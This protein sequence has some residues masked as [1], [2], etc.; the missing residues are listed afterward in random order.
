MIVV[1]VLAANCVQVRSS[2]HA[3]ESLATGTLIVHGN[4]FLIKRDYEKALQ[5]YNA[6]MAQEPTSWQPYFGRA[7][8]FISQRKW[9][10]A[11][12]DL[13]SVVRLKPGQLYAALLRGDVNGYFGNY[14]R[15]L[16][17]YDR[18]VRIA[19]PELRLLGLC[20]WAQNSSAWLRATCP[21]A[22]FRN[23]RQAVADATIAC[24]ITRW[25]SSAYIDTLAAAYA[26]TGDFDSAI[27]FEQ[28]AITGV[29]KDELNRSIQDPERKRAA[30]QSIVASY[31]RHLA[32]Y[33]HH[34]PWR[35]NLD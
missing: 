20:A 12:Q 26:E 18:L 7:L 5:Y 33:Q 23:G 8:V 21:D 14:S 4:Q 10:L 2:S 16:D 1:I 30:S 32:A 11:L 35:S 34:H 24:R 25:R 19:R 6:A 17:E 15:A 29:D 31:Q 27:R 28:Q 3:F 13:N 9:D 22:S